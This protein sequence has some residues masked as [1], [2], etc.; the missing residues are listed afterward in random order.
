PRVQG[1]VL[2]RVPD[3]AGPR[4]WCDYHGITVDDDGCALLYKAV[5][6]DWRSHHGATYRPGVEVSCPDWNPEPVYGGGL[7]FSP[8]PWM[9]DRYQP[10]TERYVACRVRL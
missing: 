9:A 5:D 8:R 2:I 6:G 4:E 3:L 10:V 7:H 1:G